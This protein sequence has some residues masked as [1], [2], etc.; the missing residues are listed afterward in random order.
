MQ[1]VFAKTIFY[2]LSVEIPATWTVQDVKFYMEVSE[3][4]SNTISY[5]NDCD[6][7]FG[8]RPRL[9]I[10]GITTTLVQQHN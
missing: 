4:R 10:A 3:Q 2:C 8:E 5:D 1:S 6:S 7:D 9:Q